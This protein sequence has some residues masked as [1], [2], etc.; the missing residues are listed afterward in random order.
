MKWVYGTV[1]NQDANHTINKRTFN[2]K[3]LHRGCLCVSCSY[4]HSHRLPFHT[5]YTQNLF[6]SLVII[7]Q[8]LECRNDIML[9]DLEIYRLVLFLSCCEFHLKCNC[10]CDNKFGDVVR[11]NSSHCCFWIFYQFP[12]SF[13]VFLSLSLSLLHTHMFFVDICNF[14]FISDFS[15]MCLF[16]VYLNAW[17]P[18]YYMHT[19][20]FPCAIMQLILTEMVIYCVQY[21]SSISQNDSSRNNIIS[22]PSAIASLCVCVCVNALNGEKFLYDC[23]NYVQVKVTS[24]L[25]VWIYCINAMLY[26]YSLSLLFRTFFYFRSF[27]SLHK[28]VFLCYDI[29]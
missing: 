25:L 26:Y 6:S 2:Y 14:D 28:T 15:Q 22:L 17:L 21:G 3:L 23:N 7:I 8:L 5:N 20:T 18:F 1:E 12:C 4:I 29:Q 19:C 27:Y 16:A 10:V 24:C 9:F 13:T 11:C